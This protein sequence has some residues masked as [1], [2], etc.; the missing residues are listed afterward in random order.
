MYIFL[1]LKKLRSKKVLISAVCFIVIAILVIF[2]MNSEAV[3]VV[4]SSEGYYV[5]VIMYHSILKDGSLQGKYV[6]SP[7][8]LERDLQYL[9]ENGYSSVTVSDLISYVEDGTPLPEKPIMLTF[10]D[11]YYNN[12]LYAFPLMK[13]YDFKMVLSVI[14]KYSEIYSE[15]E[16]ENA[17]YSHCTWEQLRE[18]EDSGYV[19]V[20]NHSFDMHTTD[21]GRNGSKK[22]SWESFEIYEDIFSA[23]ILKCQNLLIEKSGITPTAFTYPFGAISNE[24]VNILKNLGFKASFSCEEK[25]NI[26]TRDPKC[27]FGIY[28]YL[29]PTGESSAAY[30]EST[31]KIDKYVN[32]LE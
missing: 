10:D 1:N 19:E 8:Q 21:K 25:V 16:D 32:I 3:S 26:I 30:F 12:Y 29:R 11:G 17:Y 28:R 27:L 5:P 4:H 15:S 9:S 13:K 18:M 23:D 14:G 20:Q 22:N 6:V 7:D 2:K 31:V 24:S